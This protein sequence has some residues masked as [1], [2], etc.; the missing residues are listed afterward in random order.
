M[1]ITG[2]DSGFEVADR[3]GTRFYEDDQVVSVNLQTK[4][5]FSAGVLSYVS[6]TCIIHVANDKGDEEIVIKDK[7]K[8]GEFDPHADLIERLSENYAQRARE[9]LAAGVRLA[10]DNWWLDSGSLTVK[11]KHEETVTPQSDLARIDIFDGNVCIWTRDV[12]DPILKVSCNSK[13]AFVLELILGPV[14]AGNDIDDSGEGLGHVLFERKPSTATI[15]ALFMLGVAAL[16]AAPVLLV[17]AFTG[18]EPE[19]FLI[20]AGV[21]V[22][23][24]P[25]FFV[26]GY[27]SKRRTF[28]CHARG[29]HSD[30]LLGA[31]ELYY[32]DVASFV[33]SL[34]RHYTNGAY[35]GTALNM[36]FTPRDSSLKPI[37]YNK[38]TKKIDS[39][40]DLI[41]D[42]IS[43]VIA[44]EMYEQ[45]QQDKPAA[46]TANSIFKP[47][48]IEYRPSGFFGRKDWKLLEYSKVHGFDIQQ[49]TF[50]LWEKDVDKSVLQ[51]ATSAENFFPGYYLLL[52]LT[53]PEDEQ[54]AE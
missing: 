4:E 40:L 33:Y 16:L 52:M 46:W 44:V 37:E 30:G 41:R 35:T 8:P 17:L 11:N 12:N 53:A 19:L 10:G 50:H 15:I 51:E 25:V 2:K 28:R 36:K 21:A 39:D 13:N 42:H 38:H 9:A 20:G 43:R 1:K 18:R 34:T 31:R 5:K 26:G 29:V 32:T 6:R 7:L 47:E 27:A 24:S 54:P 45:L 23:L 3:K 22:V 49:G 14:I 48:G